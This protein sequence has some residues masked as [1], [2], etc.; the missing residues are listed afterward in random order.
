MKK[1]VVIV[2]LVVVCVMLFG[3]YNT[4]NKERSELKEALKYET[5]N[6]D[7]LKKQIKETGLYLYDVIDDGKYEENLLW[8]GSR[9]VCGDA[10]CV[11]V[12]YNGD[13][14]VMEFYHE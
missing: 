10:Y 3:A 9:S 1:N 7:I 12:D 6:H 14:S 2:L 8:M 4:A 13:I 5:V 11:H